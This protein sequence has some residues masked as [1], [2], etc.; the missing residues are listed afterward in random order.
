DRVRSR[1]ACAG[2]LPTVRRRERNAARTDI[3]PV[4]RAIDERCDSRDRGARDIGARAEI[5]GA[6]TPE[7]VGRSGSNEPRQFTAG[8]VV[9]A[10]AASSRSPF[11]GEIGSSIGGAF[12]Q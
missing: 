4:D 3:R 5:R 2:Y 6:G 8:L 1:T 11:H 10:D 9:R 12:A 7:V